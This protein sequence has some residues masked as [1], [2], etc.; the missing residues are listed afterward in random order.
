VRL[1]MQAWAQLDGWMIQ[2]QDELYTDP[3]SRRRV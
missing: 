1:M 3:S 2:M